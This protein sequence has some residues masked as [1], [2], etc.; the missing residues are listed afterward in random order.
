[1]ESPKTDAVMFASLEDTTKPAIF[2]DAASMETGADADDDSSSEAS[3]SISLIL[4]LLLLLLLLSLPSVTTAK[5]A[6]AISTRSKQD[7]ADMI[8]DYWQSYD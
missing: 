7:L 2:E 8:V 4:L 6:T 3:I 5:Q 1:M